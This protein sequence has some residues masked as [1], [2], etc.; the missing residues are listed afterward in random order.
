MI[1]DLPRM[2]SVLISV[3]EPLTWLVT[4]QLFVAPDQISSAVIELFCISL[5]LTIKINWRV[6]QLRLILRQRHKAA[7]ERL[8]LQ[9][10]HTF[11]KKSPPCGFL[12]E[13]SLFSI[14]KTILLKMSQS[15][16][17]RIPLPCIEQEGEA[18][19][20]GTPAAPSTPVRDEPINQPL[21]G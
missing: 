13:I 2:R 17:R 14:K 16:A 19:E 10:T 9:G 18:R 7:F 8:L 12:R 11:K 4:G 3:R 21:P 5:S 1:V 6:S 20:L 15:Y